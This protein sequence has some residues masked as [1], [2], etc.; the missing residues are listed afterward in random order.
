YERMNI[1]F[2]RTIIKASGDP[3]VDLALARTEHLPFASVSALS[4]VGDNLA[5]EFRRF[6]LAHMRL[7]AV[8]AAL[9]N[10]EGARAEAVMREHANAT[11][12]YAV[13]FVPA[14]QRVTV[15]HGD[16]AAD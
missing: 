8:V 2:H 3:A 13:C 4:V 7:H 6:N 11:L 15:L 5:P 10:G 12:R 16:V 14:R 1:R 9:V